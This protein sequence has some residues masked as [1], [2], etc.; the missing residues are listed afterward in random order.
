VTDVEIDAST[1][2][3][4]PVEHDRLTQCEAIVNAGRDTVTAVGSALREIRD[5]RLYRET[6]ETFEAYVE[7]RWGFS[8]QR[9]YQLIAAG[10]IAVDLTTA[11]D[12]PQLNE[13]QARELAPLT[14]DQRL[15][16]YRLAR[17]TAP[18]GR[19]TSAHLKSVVQV[20]NEV[21]NQ[22]AIDDGTG[23][24]VAWAELPPERRAA[25]FEASVTEDTYERLQRQRLHLERAHSPAHG[26]DLNQSVVPSDPAIPN[27]QHDAVEEVLVSA[28]PRMSVDKAAAKIT[29]TLAQLESEGFS[30]TAIHM[31]LTQASADWRATH[32][33]ASESHPVP[34]Q[35]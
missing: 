5:S 30:A 32:R 33:T 12:K 17:D 19:I 7:R 11:V 31:A 25:L 15:I 13:R 27:Q 3:L 2:A 23:Y 24:Q 16:V 34:V 14:P 9:A 10:G 8:R 4:T 26:R 1:T 18:N 6:D 29:A 20:A 22:G 21:I 35:G 28:K